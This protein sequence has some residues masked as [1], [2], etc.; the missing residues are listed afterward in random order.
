MDRIEELEN[1][2]ERY[3]TFN[4]T[5]KNL[6][7][8]IINRLLNESFL[9]LERNEDKDDYYNALDLLNEINSYLSLID[10]SVVYDKNINIIYIKNTEN[11][12]RIHLNKFDTVLLL[13]FRLLYFKNSKKASLSNLVSTSFIELK[14]EVK[15]TNIYKEEK[16]TN[17]YL[18]SL[19]NLR[20]LKL[21]SFTRNN[22]FND[23][24]Y[25]FIYP[26]ILYIAK[27]EN[28]EELNNLLKKYVLGDQNEEVSE[29]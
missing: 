28:I 13:I 5:K 16:T 29:N 1:L 9:M 20:R 24:S 19:R 17:E 8:K 4:D 10:Y 18:E 12:N 26:S 22:E 11:K 3:K 2:L 14:E 23:E 21:I 6:L 7:S 27:M 25:I 15:K